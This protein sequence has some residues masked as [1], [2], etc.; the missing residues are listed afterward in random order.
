MGKFEISIGQD[1]HHF[2]YNLKEPNNEIIMSSHGFKTKESCKNVINSVKTNSVN[3][4]M[5][6]KEIASNGDFYFNLTAPDYLIIGI[7]Q[8][9]TSMQERENGIDSVIENAPKAEV[10]DLCGN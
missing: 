10:I 3:K 9:Y 1:N 5:F 4:A 8:M 2:M 6:T 7:S